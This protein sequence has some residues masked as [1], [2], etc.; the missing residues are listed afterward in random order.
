MSY[1][2]GIDLGT[3]YTA[4]AVTRDGRT[5]IFQLGD[6]TA[7]IPSTVLLR[8]DGEM[9][10]GDAAARRSA[11][12]PGRGAREFKRRLGD[13]VPLLLGGTPYSAEALSAHVLKTVL[14]DVAAREGGA[15]DA[16]AVT[17]P[18]SYSSYRMDLLSG[19]CRQAG[20]ARPVFCS[21][22]TAAAV[23][24]AS[25]ERIAPGER[26]AVYDL[27]GGTFD[28]AILE[29]TGDDF[30]LVGQPDGIDRLGG[31][32][33]DQS[34]FGHVA[35][36]LELNLKAI[37]ETDTGRAALARLREECREAK[38]SL[39]SDT[40]TTIQVLLPGV[41]TQVRLTRAEFEAMIRPR[42]EET[43][44]A[45]RRAAASAGLE[46]EQVDRVLLVGGSSRIPLVGQMVSAAAGSPVMVDTHPKHA[47][48]LGAAMMAA[49]SLVPASSEPV[50]VL[51]GAAAPAAKASVPPPPA[52]QPPSA[53]GM[54]EGGDPAGRGKT[55]RL[56]VIGLG[57]LAGVLVIAGAAFALTR[58][59][60]G[61]E[62]PADVVGGGATATPAWTSAPAPTGTMAAAITNAPTAA[63][64][65]IATPAWTATSA[66]TWTPV[67]VATAAPT[68]TPVPTA[69]A[70][71]KGITVSY[72][73][74]MVDFTTSSLVLNGVSGVVHLHFF[75][76]TVSL[77][78]AGAPGA[79]PWF[80]YGG[81]SPFTGYSVAEKPAG[82]KQMCVL[83]ANPDHSVRPGTG[84]C[85][86]LP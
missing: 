2:L 38:E 36:S 61:D 22:P 20:I 71:I 82:A 12:E 30:S 11:T 1:T 67:V 40:E 63:S 70:A 6:R 73:N 84:N 85:F 25:H 62:K 39:S 29:K 17:H 33:F 77:A 57:G 18:A 34:V 23:Y 21:E 68:A 44:A 47:I 76:D 60:S 19:V 10:V 65:T 28:A 59:D 46:L 13:P 55:A 8:E 16:V 53:D 37:G 78:N 48:A 4:A 69:S 58:D 72:G 86:T 75:W 51:T 3:T 50:P 14:A 42:I 35:D 49:R 74:Y 45:L 5:E 64:T 81:A 41:Q 26:V 27:G 66:P 52:G 31:I 54:R 43:V 83:V 80:V 7:S 56:M 15:P 9:L 24:Y 79:G 32:D